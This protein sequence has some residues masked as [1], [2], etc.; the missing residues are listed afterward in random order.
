M[1]LGRAAGELDL[2]QGRSTLGARLSQRAGAAL[3]S[4]GIAS[5]SAGHSTSLASRTRQVAANAAE[6]SAV[7]RSTTCSGGNNGAAGGCGV[8]SGG[9]AGRT[10][11]VG[12]VRVL[13][14]ISISL[15]A[16]LSSI[17]EGRRRDG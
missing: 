8:S 6:P 1:R 15:A 14:A 3:I 5:P 16:D 4:A 17:A 7:I 2:P 10:E 13:C 12:L 9:L 11:W